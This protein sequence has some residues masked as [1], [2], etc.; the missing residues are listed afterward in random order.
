MK[1]LFHVFFSLAVSV[2]SFA[3]PLDHWQVRYPHL[4]APPPVAFRSVT[5]ENG[6]FVAVGS[7]GAIFSSGDAVNWTPRRSGT[8]ALL[9]GIA[10]APDRFVAVGG[11]GIDS[12]GATVL[13]STNAVDWAVRRFSSVQELNAITW[14]G[15]L[16]VACGSE[17]AIFTSPDGLS[18]TKRISGTA[19]NLV[20]LAY[21][22]GEF[23]A[24]TRRETFTRSRN[25]IS[26]SAHTGISLQTITFGKNKF[27]ALSH[28]GSLEFSDDGILWS[29]LSVGRST[30][31]SAL[32]AGQQFFAFGG[33]AILQVDETLNVLPVYQIPG[34]LSG[35]DH[36]SVAFGNDRY[37]A[38]GARAVLYSKDGAQW[39]SLFS[40][41]APSDSGQDLVTYANGEFRAPDL[42]S[43]D[44]VTWFDIARFVEF[45]EP[46]S[47]QFVNGLY[48]AFGSIYDGVLNDYVGAFAVST[49]GQ[50]WTMAGRGRYFSDAAFGNSRWVVTGRGIS[51]V[52]LD[53]LSWDLQTLPANDTGSAVVFG[54][55]TFVTLG[56]GSNI[57]RN[58]V[59]SST[60]GIDW[61]IR[62][63]ISSEYLEAIAF[64]NDTFVAVG[65]AN[66]SSLVLTSTN[67]INWTK[68]TAGTPYPLRAV[69]YGDGQFAAVGGI[70]DI[71][72]STNAIQWIRHRTDL[73]IALQSIA[74]GHHSFVAAGEGVIL[75]SDPLIDMAPAVVE[76]MET[77]KGH[78]GDD[79]ILSVA[80]TG[81]SPLA[82]QW[83]RNQEP[84]PGATNLMLRV[85]NLKA[86]DFTSTFSVQVSNSFGFATG[87]ESYILPPGSLTEPLDHWE[88]IIPLPQGNDLHS[89]AF[90]N[91]QFVAVGDNGTVISSTD[92]SG[93]TPGPSA[94][95]GQLISLTHGDGQF[96]AIG[97][98]SHPALPGGETFF[99]QSSDGLHWE[100]N[101]L[102][103]PGVLTAI[104][105]GNH[106]FVT[107]GYAGTI[108]SSSEGIHWRVQT[109]S[110]KSELLSV[111]FQNGLFVAVG[112]TDQD[113][114]H[115]L[116]LTSSDGEQWTESFTNMPG[117]LFK[118][119]SGNGQFLAA[120]HNGNSQFLLHSLDGIN[121]TLAPPSVSDL[122]QLYFAN[123]VFLAVSFHTDDG[124][125]AIYTSDDG[126]NWVPRGPIP[127][128]GVESLVG[129]GDSFVFV[130]ADG[131]IAT[132]HDLT[133]WR[134]ESSSNV[135]PASDDLG[136][137][138]ILFGAG[139]YLA[140]SGNFVAQ[141]QDGR[142][143]TTTEVPGVAYFNAITYG[144]GHFSAVAS[145]PAGDGLV[146]TS[147]EG[148]VWTIVRTNLSLT[149][150]AFGNGVYVAGGLDGLVTAPDGINWRQLPIPITNSIN[151][152]SFNAGRFFAAGASGSLLISS[153]AV[154]WKEVREL[155]PFALGDVTAN[156]WAIVAGAGGPWTSSFSFASKDGDNW[157]KGT[158]VQGGE[159]IE[160]L[161][162]GED[163]FVAVA[164]WNSFVPR[165]FSST[166]G[167]VWEPHETPFEVRRVR[168][169]NG[170]FWALAP[171]GKILQTRPLSAPKFDPAVI[172]RSSSGV[173]N[174]SVA[175][176]EKQAVSIEASSNLK[177]WEPVRA[178]ARH[179]TIIEI[180]DSPDRTHRF[181]RASASP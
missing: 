53:G 55:G 97:T 165:I 87:K 37:V 148:R 180:N 19:E 107:V 112:R 115:C 101:V 75:Q 78:P 102:F 28:V 79:A 144:D 129:D 36:W 143:W 139:T 121:W 111:T 117:L 68:R 176:S 59:L 63:A 35:T 127:F 14:A 173:I 120:G 98:D 1:D 74:F 163:L 22:N 96:I 108:A 81:T 64:A 66:S 140:Y 34:E 69:S 40:I 150:I 116:M 92:G 50:S 43:P 103:T 137:L 24:I 52:S 105:F 77:V 151:K 45:A 56:A 39:H 84:I 171:G 154:E 157:I 42:R 133:A 71:F 23:I 82:F 27:F 60:N 156:E 159:Q 57:P 126:V 94:G 21:G 51:A 33:G 134:E 124:P 90:G 2:A 25:G 138:D 178:T 152:I 128:A 54:N 160:S 104:A 95:Q 147:L 10:S 170:S 177:T 86:T 110:P 38:V 172:V 5:F 9:N 58:T 49:N 169:L 145:D 67:G 93:W 18:W 8:T 20:G 85:P 32:Y 100:R 136:E 91:G 76:Q 15:G 125:R 135:F 142:L 88:W 83:F 166:D 61:V 46:P 162:Y 73:P 123:G 174:L 158:I 6:T 131:L 80:A 47:I 11:A 113:S 167:V 41:E 181:Y 114:S 99:I 155:T 132:S 149:S 17:G 141:S 106:H 29:E 70:G 13:T 16:F 175:R 12:A 4:P 179:G 7:T 168:Y 72:S 62:R 109:K 31:S 122:R 119:V 164:R 30:F 130:G 3:H 146:L 65:S 44:G 118:V 89:V 153:N 48:F 26:W 161:T